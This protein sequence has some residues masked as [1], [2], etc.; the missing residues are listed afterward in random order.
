MHNPI[1]H[2]YGVEINSYANRVAFIGI[3]ASIGCHY[4]GNRFIW[5]I[6]SGSELLK[7]RLCQDIACLL[8]D[9]ALSNSQWVQRNRDE[10]GKLLFWIPFL[11]SGIFLANQIGDSQ[12]LL[13][14]I[15]LTL[16]IQTT[17]MSA[18]AWIV[19]GYLAQKEYGSSKQLNLYRAT[20]GVKEGATPEEIKKAYR[21]LAKATHS[22][23]N[24]GDDSQFIA[25]K[26][27]YDAL[28][29]PK[30]WEEEGAL[31]DEQLSKE[32]LVHALSA[33]WL[34]DSP[35]LLS[36]GVTLA[37]KSGKSKISQ[38]IRKKPTL[39]LQNSPSGSSN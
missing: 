4:L 25:V 14:W 39:L 33:F 16:K 18:P 1:T 26:K 8:L 37:D 19:L 32:N 23:K 34:L 27:A 17:L 11:P 12:L 22:D 13:L 20:L 29:K 35:Y 24:K 2:A 21:N 3:T 5:K 6:C 9:R 31:L 10:L 38:P 28:M 7:V 36:L 30:T 15:P